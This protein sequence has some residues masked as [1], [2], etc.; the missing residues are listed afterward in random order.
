M[1]TRPN[2]VV[3]APSHTH[4][5]SDSSGWPTIQMEH[6]I[7]VCTIATEFLRYCSTT[8]VWLKENLH[9]WFWKN[10]EKCFVLQ[11]EKNHRN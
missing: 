3:I 5:H 6:K 10:Q 11:M 8:A 2:I 4:K 1:Q 9:K 7:I